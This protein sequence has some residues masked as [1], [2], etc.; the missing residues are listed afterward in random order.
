M[1][2]PT[3]A[4]RK[5]KKL[6]LN[7]EIPAGQ[8][9]Y[10]E[11]LTKRLKISQTP[12]REALSRLVVE[13]YVTKLPNKGYHVTEITEEELVELFDVREA[14]ETFCIGQV[15]Q[16]ITPVQ[17][18]S[19]KN[20]LKFHTKALA[21]GTPLLERHMIHKDFH[22]RVASIAGNRKVLQILQDTC[23]K[24]L[25]ERKAKGILDIEFE[26]HSAH[27]KLL[28]ALERKDVDAAKEITAKHLESV[29]TQILT[30]IRQR[31]QLV[32]ANAGTSS[33]G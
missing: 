16:R 4:Y 18:A 15:I 28:K 22:L 29:K 2:L 8:K 30:K 26:V 5:I 31:K 11:D 1:D 6:I 14:L 21:K 25:L 9:L 12:I 33:L 19:L 13:G 20:H 27:E 7:Q 3:L 24:I 10:H 17:L 32:R 23:E